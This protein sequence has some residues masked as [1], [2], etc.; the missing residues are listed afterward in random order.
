MLTMLVIS[1][2]FF[3]CCFAAVWIHIAV[4][5]YVR[6]YIIIGSNSVLRVFETSLFRQCAYKDTHSAV[7]DV[8][9]YQV[10]GSISVPGTHVFFFYFHVL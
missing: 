2:V 3:K 10:L 7:Y 5:L 6:C 1:V 8:T 9:S 4:P